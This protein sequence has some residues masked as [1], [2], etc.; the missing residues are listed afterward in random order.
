VLE[1]YCASV[2]P[3]IALDL[4]T[5]SEPRRIAVKHDK[6]NGVAETLLQQP[7]APVAAL[8]SYYLQAE[9]L[10]ALVNP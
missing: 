6:N 4:D 1:H 7:G 8:V 3:T 9:V 2:I 10:R 5:R